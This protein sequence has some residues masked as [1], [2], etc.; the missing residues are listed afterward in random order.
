MMKSGL[1]LVCSLF[2]FSVCVIFLNSCRKETELGKLE[3]LDNRAMNSGLGDFSTEEQKHLSFL[4]SNPDIEYQWA[5]EID[6]RDYWGVEG[7]SDK[8]FLSWESGYMQ[9]VTFGSL[10][11]IDYVIKTEEAL[12]EFKRNSSAYFEAAEFF[13]GYQEEPDGGD[14]DDMGDNPNIPPTVSI[15]QVQP[16]R[17]LSPDEWGLVRTEETMGINLGVHK[18]GNIWRAVLKAVVGHYSIQ[19]RLLPT[20]SEVTGIRGNTTT[21]N[22]C[23]QIT[24]LNNLG[25]TNAQWYMISAVQAHENVHVAS[26]LPTLNQ[27]LPD[28]ETSLESITVSNTGQSSVAALSQVKALATFSV[29]S[30]W[31]NKFVFQIGEDHKAGAACDQAERKVVD[32]MIASICN[33]AKAQTPVWPTCSVCP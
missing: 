31:V 11:R 29:T 26:L 18:E 4:M 10:N 32:T 27:A 22:Y 30:F 9:A 5:H 15:Q 23:K 1:T 3:N 6:Y 8:Y 28:I 16:G 20:A 13:K 19:V 2:L 14:P 12:A 17:E 21:D 7:I 33:S 24:D 25:P